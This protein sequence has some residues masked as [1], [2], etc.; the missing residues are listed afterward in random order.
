MFTEEQEEM[1]RE[2]YAPTASDLEF[3]VLVSIARVRRLNPLL[4]HIH[5]VKR[6]NKIIDHDGR[7]RWVDKW[8]CQVSIDGLR[9]KAEETG[10]YDG[11]DEPEF[12]REEEGELVARVRVFRK[13]IERP[14]V[15]VAFWSEFVQTTRKGDPVRMWEQMPRHMLAKCAEALALRKA[16]PEE[17]AGLYTSDEMGQAINGRPGDEAPQSPRPVLPQAPTPDARALAER[18]AGATTLDAGLEVLRVARTMPRV[19]AVA[20][21]RLIELSPDVTQLSVFV[22]SVQNDSLPED[23]RSKLLLLAEERRAA[24][25]PVDHDVSQ[26]EAS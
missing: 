10:L 18:A 2:M 5:F 21:K 11:Q 1:I 26:A 7:E 15:G 3:K 14:F 6:P 9:A 19:R 4:G 23:I 25:E 24:L 12:S 8:T 20:Y 13:G 22:V 17:L 16:F